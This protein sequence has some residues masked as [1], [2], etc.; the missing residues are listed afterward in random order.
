MAGGLLA[1][2]VNTPEPPQLEVSSLVYATQLRGFQ[3]PVLDLFPE[4]ESEAYFV[5]LDR[6]ASIL[7]QRQTASRVQLLSNGV[8]LLKAWLSVEV[9]LILSPYN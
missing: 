3:L 5:A 7:A 4:P 8:V 9:L 2:A 1:A 6:A